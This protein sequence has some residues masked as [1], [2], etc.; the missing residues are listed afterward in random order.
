[1]IMDAVAAEL[2][3]TH[4]CKDM[5]A[6]TKK[7]FR[8]LQFSFVAVGEALS[9][10]MEKEIV[11]SDSD[12]NRLLGTAAAAGN[13]ARER[14]F[15]VIAHWLDPEWTDDEDNVLIREMALGRSAAAISR[16]CLP[17]KSDQMARNR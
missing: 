16:D 12:E 14:F 13:F 6:L 8:E 10:T 1:M 17:N 5:E 11:D 7:E 3:R 4:E 9:K 2:E 15:R